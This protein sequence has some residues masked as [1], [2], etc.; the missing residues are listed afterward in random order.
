MVGVFAPS[1]LPTLVTAASMSH[2]SEPHGCLPCQ[3]LR[4][5][6][7]GSGA[8]HHVAI[9]CPPRPKPAN[10]RGKM[11]GSPSSSVSSLVDSCV[12]LS[13]T[14]LSQHSCGGPCGRELHFPHQLSLEADR[15]WRG[16]GWGKVLCWPIRGGQLL[17]C[18][19]HFLAACWP[20]PVQTT[21]M[22]PSPE[23]STGLLFTPKLF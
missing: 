2:G 14:H 19:Q 18:A 5:G 22:L 12:A 9:V 13:A 3:E 11:E 4:M 7:W 17:I 16:R 10:W 1:S 23:G 6:G 20:Q 15:R 21:S 8:P